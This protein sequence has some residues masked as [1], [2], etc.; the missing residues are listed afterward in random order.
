MFKKRHFTHTHTNTHTHS[1]LKKA[2]LQPL[3]S[4]DLQNVYLHGHPAK[5]KLNTRP[6][7]YHPNTIPYR[8]QNTEPEKSFEL[9]TP[10]LSL[11]IP[12]P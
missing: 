1:E 5:L 2:V 9:K 4:F 11:G 6:A 8:H 3:T 7:I 10:N 12:A